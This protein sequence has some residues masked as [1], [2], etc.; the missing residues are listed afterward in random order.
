MQ[1]TF[2][3]NEQDF[4]DAYHLFM[5]STPRHR[6][7]IRQTMPWVGGALI[8]LSIA[9]LVTEPSATLAVLGVIFGLYMLYCGFALRRFFRNIYRKDPRFKEEFSME[10]SDAGVRMSSPTE[11]SQMKWATFIRALESDRIFMLFQAEWLFNVLPKHAF[12]PGDVDEFRELLRR[13][14]AKTELLQR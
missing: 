1:V 9:V 14:V 7:V 13:N 3:L 8:L 10:A 12:S 6:R 4:V 5:K 2:R 11:D